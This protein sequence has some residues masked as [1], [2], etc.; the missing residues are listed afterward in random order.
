MNV[1]EMEEK[2]IKI[3]SMFIYPIRGVRGIEVDECEVTPAGLKWDRLWVFVDSDSRKPLDNSN[4]E[5]TSY[6]RL[7]FMENNNVR[8]FL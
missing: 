6:F 7:Q 8:L 2:E 4:N 1:Q 3:K 5:I